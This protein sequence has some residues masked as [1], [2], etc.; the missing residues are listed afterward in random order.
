MKVTESNI[1]VKDLNR[2][3][4]LPK[5]SKR[6]KVA[7]KYLSRLWTIRYFS[8][9]EFINQMVMMILLL[10]IVRKTLFSKNTT[11][12]LWNVLNINKW[13]FLVITK[14]IIMRVFIA[15]ERRYV[16]LSKC[17]WIFICKDYGP[18]FGCEVW[19]QIKIT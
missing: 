16:Y 19:A 5:D 12:Q 18:P 9:K 8:I 4:Q 17:W 11:N 2:L 3:R 14:D 10:G 15:L 6:K 1:L 13:C 7:A